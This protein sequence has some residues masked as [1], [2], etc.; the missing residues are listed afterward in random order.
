MM[1][2]IFIMGVLFVM[3]FVMVGPPPSGA[4]RRMSQRMQNAM[5]IR[6]IQQGMVVYAQGSKTF[7]P[8]FTSDGRNDAGRLGST[9]PQPHGHLYGAPAL[10]SND[11]TAIVYAV[12]LSGNYIIPKYLI[13]PLEPRKTKAAPGPLHIT[14]DNYSYA[15]LS[16]ADPTTDKGRRA[17]WTDTQ[18][19]QAPIAGDR[20]KAIDPTMRTTSLHVKTTTADSNDWQG[21]IVWNDGHSTFETTGR[22]AGDAIKIGQQTGKAA[23]IDDL[24][25]GAAA[26]G[27]LPADTNALFA[28]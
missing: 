15:L 10:S 3:L 25:D 17:E 6:G 11:P 27:D 26:G 16:V 18:N 20:G 7:Y 24:F 2:A 14:N 12:L 4:S 1:A 19:S 21:S 28:Y 8:G 13:S 22:F 23:D 5:Q 9:H